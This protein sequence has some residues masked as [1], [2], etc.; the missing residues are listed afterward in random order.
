MNRKEMALILGREYLTFPNIGLEKETVDA[1]L[2]HFKD[3]DVAV[4]DTA[5]K[6]CIEETGRKFFPT[7]GEVSA[8]IKLL[9][10]PTLWT[11][12]EVWC[13]LVKHASNSM[14]EVEVLSR[15]KNFP[16][17]ETALRAVGWDA[18]R[19]SDIQKELPFVRNKFIEI[20]ENCTGKF[21]ERSEAQ[22]FNLDN[23]Q[24]KKLVNLALGD[25]N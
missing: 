19:Y 18:I 23:P 16:A 5:I 21:E 10:K 13:Q 22:R 17:I 9:T 4:F 15:V 24:V 20:Y 12:A 7:V 3:T 11:G 6:L 2:S 14:S 25:G 8:K 1:W